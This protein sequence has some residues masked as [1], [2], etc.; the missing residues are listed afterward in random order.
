MLIY[1]VGI[2]TPRVW[3][4]LEK[5]VWMNRKR[6]VLLK[7]ERRWLDAL[8]PGQCVRA[9]VSWGAKWWPSIWYKGTMPASCDVTLQRGAKWSKERREVGVQGRG[10]T[11]AE[12]GNSSNFNQVFRCQWLL[13]LADGETRL[14]FSLEASNENAKYMERIDIEKWQGL[15]MVLFERL[16]LNVARNCD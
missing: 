6:L 11:L 10:E 13:V 16:K 7:A 5:L 8:I 2:E 9:G 4:C 15:S 1:P 14:S 12:E 3:S